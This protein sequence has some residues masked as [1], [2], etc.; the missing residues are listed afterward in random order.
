MTRSIVRPIKTRGGCVRVMIDNRFGSVLTDVEPFASIENF[1]GW[2]LISAADDAPE[3]K[4]ACATADALALPS[5]GSITQA[6]R[7]GQV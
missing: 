2:V 7:R 5:W 3:A 4:V 1:P 6:I